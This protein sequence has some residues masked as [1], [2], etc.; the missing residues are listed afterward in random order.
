MKKRISVCLIITALVLP[1]SSNGQEF[2]SPI[3]FNH[4]DA[5][6]NSPC[7]VKL[8]TG[9]EIEGIFSGT[10]MSAPN[11]LSQILVKPE[12]GKLRKFRAEEISSFWVKTTARAKNW[13]MLPGRTLTVNGWTMDLDEDK[14]VYGDYFIFCPAFTG[15]KGTKCRLYQ[16]VNPGHD[17]HIKVLFYEQSGGNSMGTGMGAD[18]TYTKTGR[19][20]YLLVVNGKSYEAKAGNYK[21]VS[22]QVYKECPKMIEIFRNEFRWDDLAKH[23]IVYDEVC[24]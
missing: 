23:V 18:V 4:T 10:M 19:I 22:A 24:N 6:F 17:S 16:L 12:N 9:E 13:A 1:W 21:E 20:V 14:K 11:Y 7:I 3:D 8:L 5:L 15:N 2:M